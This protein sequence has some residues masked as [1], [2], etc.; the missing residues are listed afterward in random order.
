MPMINAVTLTSNPS[1]RRQVTIPISTTYTQT[2]RTLLQ[3][4]GYEGSI[5]AYK[6]QAKKADGTT[7]REAFRLAGVPKTSGTDPVAVAT[8]FTTH[9]Q[10]V[11][12][13]VEYASEPSERDCDCPI[14]STGAAFTAQVVVMP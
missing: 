5:V 12:A 2:M 10:T 3:A 8:D 13:G 1:I 14:N 6:I 9:G 11:A 7:D 4:A